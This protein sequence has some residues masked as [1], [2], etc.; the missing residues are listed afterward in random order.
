M[1]LLNKISDFT[2]FPKQIEKIVIEEKADAI[3]AAGTMAGA[4]AL[5][6]HKKLNILYYV[7]FYEPHAL[8]MLDTGVWRWYDP[9]FILQLKWEKEQARKA[10][11]LITV[12]EKFRQNVIDKNLA[13]EAN[14]LTARNAPDMA[15]FYFLKQNRAQLRKQLSIKPDTVVGVYVG[16]YGDLYYKEEAFAI[17]KQCFAII[18]HFRLIILSP[19]PQEEIRGYLGQFQIDASKVHVA[20]VPHSEVPQYLSAAD[21]AFATIKS[22][23]SARYCSPVKIGEYWANGLPVLLTEGVG[24][25]SDIIR[26]EGGGA[27][28]NL[29][30]EGSVERALQKILQMLKDPN[31][32][33]EIPKLAQKYRSPDRLREA[34]EYFFSQ[35]Q[36]EQP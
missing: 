27:T 31:H 12:S 26:N 8:Y 4:L 28:Y 7:S 11:G 23:P 29:K 35:K 22:Y 19:Q 25:D 10:Q 14:V 33:Q 15:S 13:S 17:Y 16:K 24:D 18:P 1:N 21:F 5:L 3:V 36:E 34:Y 20:S 30:E 6:V 32:R 9:R 2:A